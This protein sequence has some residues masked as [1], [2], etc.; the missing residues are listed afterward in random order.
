[1]AEP[2]GAP[3]GVEEPPRE[4]DQEPLLEPLEEETP[5]DRRRVYVI[6]AFVVGTVALAIVLALFYSMPSAP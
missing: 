5:E 2:E 1:M 6:A 4:S 3:A